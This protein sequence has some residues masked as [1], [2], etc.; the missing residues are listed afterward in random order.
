MKLLFVVLTA[1]LNVEGGIYISRLAVDTDLKIC[2]A[3]L[4]FHNA[5]NGDCIL[6]ATFQNFKTI[7]K[8]LTYTKVM[9]AEDQNDR[10]FRREVF[11]SVWDAEKMINGMQGNALFR[12]F[13]RQILNSLDFQFK[14]PFVPIRTL[15]TWI[16]SL[17]TDSTISRRFIEPSI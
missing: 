1:V 12:K 15:V 11:S 6:N 16:F 13:S 7:T 2:N 3:S 4:T 17:M 5:K 14:T 10:E 8:V 9:I